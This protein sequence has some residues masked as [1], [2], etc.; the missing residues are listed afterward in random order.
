LQRQNETKRLGKRRPAALEDVNRQANLLQPLTT[1]DRL[2][3]SR[4][5]RLADHA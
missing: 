1:V 2:G 5:K 3:I 4:Q